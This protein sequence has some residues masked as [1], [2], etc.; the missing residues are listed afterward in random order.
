M[1]TR[2]SM[3][4]PVF[5]ALM[6]IVIIVYLFSTLKQ[7]T[8]SCNKTT[9]YDADIKLIE[10]VVA[11][12]DGKKITALYVTKKIILPEQF[13]NNSTIN[14][15]KSSLDN[16]LSYLEDRVKYNTDSTG[17]TVKINVEDNKLVL[18]DNLTFIDDGGNL[19]V[20]IN[21]NIKSSEV[22][23]LSVGDNYTDGELMKKL[24]NNRYS[25]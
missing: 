17:L 23:T 16:T 7:S 5:I 25:C 10:T 22:V 9:V 24:K 18:L 11:N 4:A 19:V 13:N 1:S 8:I 2:K 14:G 12:T 3:K 15:I 21:S 6:F 20:K